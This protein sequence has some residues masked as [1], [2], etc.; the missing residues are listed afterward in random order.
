MLPEYD[1]KWIIKE[2]PALTVR[3]MVLE[4]HSGI[5]H[6]SNSTFLNVRY[7]GIFKN[8][9]VCNMN[10]S[11]NHCNMLRYTISFITLTVGFLLFLPLYMYLHICYHVYIYYMMGENIA[12]ISL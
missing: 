12:Y 1:R 11:I 8:I 4:H 7:I 6:A 2:V 3:N 9:L 5:R 10:M